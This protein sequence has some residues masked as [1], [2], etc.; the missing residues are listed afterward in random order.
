MFSG[1]RRWAMMGL[2]AAGN[3]AL[4]VGIA[5]V[6]GLCASDQ[7]DLGVETMVRHAQATAVSSWAGVTGDRMELVQAA[8]TDPA[9]LP[10]RAQD[11][12]KESSIALILP[13]DGVP[14]E[15]SPAAT[16]PGVATDLPPSTGEPSGPVAPSNADDEP[17]EPALP[18]AGS[19]APAT[20]QTDLEPGSETGPADPPIAARADPVV[21]VSQIV[22]VPLLLVDPEFHS[23][24]GLNAEMEQS[25]P[26]RAV[27]IR[28]EEEA[29]NRE[30][31]TLW[32]ENPAL[33]YRDIQVDFQNNGVGISG[34]VSVLG[35][36]VDAY[37][38]GTLVARDCRPQLEVE[39]V[40]LAGI[41]TPRFVRARVVTMAEEAMAWYPEDYALCLEQIVLEETRATFYGHRR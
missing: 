6:V 21:A 15:E 23:L 3:L 39:S 40:S 41:T 25:V 22:S 14:P 37:L 27:Q 38:Q 26:G 31:E 18:T 9:T 11:P 4:W 34:K 10:P 19:P 36:Q 33:P 16:L 2:L 13:T 7:V 24:E 1:R 32:V 12:E 8:G 5:Y 28:Y 30:I 35:L 17:G 29:L 20:E